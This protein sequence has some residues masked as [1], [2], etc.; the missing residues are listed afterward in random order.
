MH[1]WLLL[2]VLQGKEFIADN[3]EAQAQTL[4]TSVS[5]VNED[6]QGVIDSLHTGALAMTKKVSNGSC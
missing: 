2:V 1:K 4:A 3:K 5:A 6:L